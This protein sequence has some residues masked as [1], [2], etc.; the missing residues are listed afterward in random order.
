MYCPYERA[1]RFLQAALLDSGHQLGLAPQ[2]LEEF[3]HVSTD[4]RR[5]ERPLSIGKTIYGISPG[6]PKRPGRCGLLKT[7]ILETFASVWPWR[8]RA[9]IPNGVW[10]PPGTSA[11]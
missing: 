8:I 4:P 9:R 5:F 2:V 6:R 10:E 1:H 11:R 3:I 7:V